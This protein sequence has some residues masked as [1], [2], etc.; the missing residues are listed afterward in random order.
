MP[1]L[2]FLNS[3]YK[4]T[5]IIMPGYQESDLP[6]GLSYKTNNVIWITT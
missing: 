5:I 3:Y 2:A 6:I 1:Y 4:F